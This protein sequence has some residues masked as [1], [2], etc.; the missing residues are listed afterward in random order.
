MSVWSSINLGDAMLADEEKGRIEES[1]RSAFAEARGPKE[2]ALFVRH[3]SEGRLH[4]EVKL[5]FSPACLV[6]ARQVGALPCDPPSPDGLGLLVGSKDAW[7][8]L[9]PNHR[10]RR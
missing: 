3:E 4:C 8:A 10:H 5:Y 7:R 9:F 1:F 6:V 2:M